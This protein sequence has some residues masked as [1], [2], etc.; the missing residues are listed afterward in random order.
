MSHTI[1]VFKPTPFDP[2]TGPSLT[3]DECGWDW[4]EHTIRKADGMHIC[5]PTPEAMEAAKAAVAADRLARPA[6]Y[7]PIE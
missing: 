1:P 7:R 6:Q 3:C 5:E 2:Y 4:D